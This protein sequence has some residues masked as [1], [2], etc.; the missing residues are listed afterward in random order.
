MRYAHLDGLNRNAIIDLALFHALVEAQ[1]RAAAMQLA[2]VKAA[3][4]RAR[5]SGASQGSSAGMRSLRYALE[6]RHPA[7]ERA[8]IAVDVLDVVGATHMLAGAGVQGDVQA[9]GGVGEGAI[10]FRCRSASNPDPPTARAATWSVVNS[11]TPILV[12]SSAD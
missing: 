12:N 10:G 8:S 6:A 5:A 9:A 1:A 3:P 11:S 4:H 2:C 7:L